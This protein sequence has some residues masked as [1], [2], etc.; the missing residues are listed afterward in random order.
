M[1]L[2][3]AVSGSGSILHTLNPRLHADQVVW[4]ADHA[5]DQVLFFDLTFLPLIEAIAGRVKTIKALRR[6]DRP[7]P[8]AGRQ[9]GAEPALLRRAGRGRERPS[10]TG[11]SSTRTRRRR[12]ATPR[13]RRAIRR[14]RSTATARRCCTP[15]RRRCRTRSNCS[16][17]DTILPVVPMFHVN[18]WGL[19]YVGLHG[20]RE[21]GVPG[22]VPRRQE[23]LR[24]VRGR[25]RHPVG[26]RADGVAGPA[27]AR[28]G[29]QPRVQHH[30]PH[31]HRRRGLPAG[32][33]A[34][35]P[36]ALRRAGAARLGHDRAEPGRHGVRAQARHC[37]WRRRAHGGAVQAGPCGLRR[38]HEDRRRRR[39]RA[40]ARRQ[41]LGRAAGARAVDRLALLQ[42]RRRRPARRRLVSRPA[43]SRRSTPTATCRSPTAART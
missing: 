19:P 43:T 11:R 40:A 23:P 6:D 4:I 38:R 26:R 22:P 5:E 39:Q 3:Y 18:A 30:A 27:H 13:A 33:D 17:R 25:R 34:H 36:G 2:Y 29:Q 1:E 10:S 15:T 9:H 20:R 7:Q 14:A 31:D 12:S 24:A 8:H 21:A 32:D 42:G 16:A 37:V 41:G 28:R 35:L